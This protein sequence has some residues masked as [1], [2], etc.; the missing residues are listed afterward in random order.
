[1]HSLRVFSVIVGTSLATMVA[2]SEDPA[3]SNGG[4]GGA[5][6]GGVATGGRPSTGGSNTGGNG[7]VT[8]PEEWGLPGAD[9]GLAANFQNVYHYFDG[10]KTAGTCFS[11]ITTTAE[12][13]EI[14]ASGTAAMVVNSMYDV[15]WGA[16]IGLQPDAMGA[17]TD[18][19]AYSGFSY[20]ITTPPPGLRVGAMM[21]GDGNSFF[22]ET[23][24]AGENTVLFDDLANGS[25]VTVPGTLDTSKITDLQWQVA[26][27]DTSDVVYD[28]CVSDITLIGG[29]GGGGGAGGDSGE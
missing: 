3:D 6:T 2:C 29:M 25:W 5:G 7:S 15:I 22:T 16:G 8:C 10:D 19:S 4:T 23:V 20:T 28:F 21:A 11:T 17:A 27:N 18:L 1:M 13:G 26:A 12:D 24:T 14:C 9:A